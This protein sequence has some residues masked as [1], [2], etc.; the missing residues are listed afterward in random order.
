M[1]PKKLAVIF[2]SLKMLFL[3]FLGDA[4]SLEFF[5][6]FKKKQLLAQ[7]FV[8]YKSIVNFYTSS[9]V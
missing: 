5:F 3:H 7:S 6:F 9:K 1:L 2:F 4:Y 8:S